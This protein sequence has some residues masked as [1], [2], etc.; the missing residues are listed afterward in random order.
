MHKILQSTLILGALLFFLVAGLATAGTIS[1][2]LQQV[3]DTAKAREK[4]AVIVQLSD[5]IN[6]KQFKKFKKKLRRL[7]LLKE[8][9]QQ[10]AAN[11][12]SLR[13]ALI[14]SGASDIQSLW[15]I[16]GIALQAKPAL[17]RK[18]AKR[19]E[20]VEIRLDAPMLLGVDSGTASG[21]SQWNIS[22]LGTDAVWAQGYRGQGVVI[23]SMDSG[24]D[25]NHAELAGNWRGGTNSWFDPHGQH[26]LPYDA[27]GHGTQTMGIMAGRNLGATAMGMAPDAQWIAVKIFDDSGFA[28]MSDIHAGYQWLL[29]PDNDPNSDDAPDIVNNSWGFAETL[30]SCQTEF[31]TDIQTLRLLGVSMVFSAGNQGGGSSSIS[32]ANN[33][34]AFAVGAVDQSGLIT[35]FSN[36][37]PSACDQS[38]VYPGAVAPGYL[39]S[40]A[41]LTFGGLF[42]E[43]TMLVSG[44][45]FAAP[46]VS[47]TMALLMS[48]DPAL[49]PDEM[50]AA[51][52]HSS[53]DQGDV[54]EDNVYGSGLV[55]VAAALAALSSTSQ[56]N[57]RDGDGFFAEGTCGTPMDCNDGDATIF[58]GAAEVVGD[59]IDQSCNGYDLS[60]DISRALYRVS[61][62]KVV[63]F[64][65]STQGSSASLAVTI[66]GMGTYAMNWNNSKNRW[67]RSI[68]KAVK[69]GL[70]PDSG[71][72]ITVSGA[73][74][75]VSASLTLK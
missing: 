48:S 15:I 3:L 8:L 11:Q 63:V 49:T 60:I 28:R 30:N 51:I 46:H 26:S 52:T 67:Q 13:S 54:G 1:P 32:P 5:N 59:A 35:S 18:L 55:N 21:A 74:G 22:M 70:E 61:Q 20:I 34:G 9:K 17:I 16:N 27:N 62:D 41:D 64:A 36:Q 45:S 39:V 14:G 24:V 40:T 37:G 7:H 6:R 33:S 10:A 2:E 57:D 43:A 4:I 71:V 66:A 44:T 47:G 50:E 58:P 75:A 42:P 53:I 31:E 25:F 12:M 72:I 56:C 68:N 69:K 29:D 23:A 19:P 65:T 73:E 38:K